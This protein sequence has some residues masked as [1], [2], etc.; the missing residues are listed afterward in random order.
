MATDKKKKVYEEREL[1]LSDGR[2]ITVRPLPISALK[3]VMSR[4]REMNDLDKDATEIDVLEIMFDCAFIT[5][6]T[7]NEN[8]DDEEELEDVLDSDTMNVVLD[9]GAGIKMGAGEEDPK[10]SPTKA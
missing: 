3:K 9:V 8:F 6:S 2:E 1:E 7:L 4:W 10:V 5:I